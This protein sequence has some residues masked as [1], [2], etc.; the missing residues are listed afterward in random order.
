MALLER[1]AALN[2][3]DPVNDVR[4]V[5]WLEPLPCEL[6]GAFNAVIG[7]DIIYCR[8]LCPGLF[9]TV[10]C[11]L[12]PGGIFAMVNGR[13]RFGKAAD[14][15]VSDAEASGLKLLSQTSMDD[16][17]QILSLYKKQ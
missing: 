5:Y 8:A 2:G 12:T 16:G 9:K 1:N 13:A 11:M 6:N 7:S 3:L 10:S 15:A 4:A 14:L 17:W